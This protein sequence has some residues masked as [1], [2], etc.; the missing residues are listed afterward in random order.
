L[1]RF[2]RIFALEF[3][4]LVRSKT[5]PALTL[6][7]VAWVL[8]LPRF[9]RGDGTEEGARELL[10]QYSLGGVFALL[11]VALVS[12]ATGSIARERA[13]RRLQLTLVRPVRYFTVA[14]GKIA[15]HVS[16]GAIV[17]AAA[18]AALSAIVD[19]GRLSWLVCSPVL[20]TPREEALAMYDVFM[21]DP[22]TSD[23]VKKS[24]KDIVLRI[25]EQ[26]AIDHYQTIPTNSSAAWSFRLGDVRGKALSV[27]LR[28]T[29]QFEMRQDV[30]GVFSL[31]EMRAQVSNITQNVLSLPL[32]G[33]ADN[34][35]IQNLVFENQGD[36]SLMLRPRR[37]IKVLVEADSFH[38]N[39]V[40]A[41]LELVSVL[42]LLVSVSIWL[43]SCL[44]RPV[45][46][47]VAIVALIVS[48]ISPSVVAQYPDQLE[49][50]PLDR[51]G[52]YL[53][54]AA[55]EITRPVSSLAPIGSLAKDECVPPGEVARVALTDLVALPLLFSFLSAFFMPRKQ[56]D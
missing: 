19:T 43:S 7:S 36:S 12:S 27:R 45:A 14:I 31:G 44:G 38:E 22:E 21:N 46:L 28:F 26:R 34:G 16:A 4:S 1:R 56:D 54:R 9:A 51:I 15:A 2:S 13:A 50:D 37:D 35:E 30:K 48:E 40:R 29:N 18:M 5:L 55:A 20:P 10:I 42:A 33:A 39:L 53:T 41:Y 32:S 3:I 47:F 24:K 11:V 49:T 6:A 17:L 23:E 25:L 8:V 52:L